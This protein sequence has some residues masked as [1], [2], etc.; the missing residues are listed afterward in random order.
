MNYKIIDKDAFY[1]LE[2]A[3]RHSTENAENNKTV[4]DFWT[5]AHLDG[6]IEKL[7]KITESVVQTYVE[8]CFLWFTKFS[9]WSNHYVKR[10]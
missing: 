3:E 9:D 8:S 10:L 2:K 1:V 5:R 6:T 7:L 4:P